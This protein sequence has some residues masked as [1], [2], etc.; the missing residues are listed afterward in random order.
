MKKEKSSPLPHKKLKGRRLSDLPIYKALRWIAGSA[1]IAII[2]VVWIYFEQFKHLSGDNAIW[3]QFGDFFGGTLN[4]I[5]SF[6]SMN[7]LLLTIHLQI[8][9]L[10]SQKRDSKKQLELLAQESF[11]TTFFQ[12]IALHNQI[13]D[14]MKIQASLNFFEGRVCFGHLHNELLATYKTNRN[15]FQND[16]EQEY[17]C[18]IFNIYYQRFD[19][20]LTG[21]LRNIHNIFKY[22]DDSTVKNLDI[23]L[24]IFFSQVSKIE[25]AIL[26]YYGLSDHGRTIKPYFEKYSFFEEIDKS[27]LINHSYQLCLYE[28]NAYGINGEKYF[29]ECKETTTLLAGNP[30]P[31]HQDP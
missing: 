3:G 20:N 12:L 16:N 25:H 1:G 10:S 5:L 21:Y 4:P 7:L 19:L 28:I 23:Y 27:M 29:Q 13:I 11:E 18:R 26:F 6:L 15:T 9:Q 30:T 2:A 14:G 17:L 8:D 22:L 24:S 31:N